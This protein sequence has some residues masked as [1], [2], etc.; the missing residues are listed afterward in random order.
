MM[1]LPPIE[2]LAV[3]ISRYKSWNKSLLIKP[4][5]RINTAVGS[6]WFCNGSFFAEFKT[7]SIAVVILYGY[8]FFVYYASC[9]SLVKGVKI[10]IGWNAHFGLQPGKYGFGI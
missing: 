7:Y 5:Y 8:A 6:L 4:T 10:L 2:H 3:N 9:L 1:C